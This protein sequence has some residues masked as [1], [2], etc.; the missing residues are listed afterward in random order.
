MTDA[1]SPAP[2]DPLQNGETMFD[3]LHGVTPQTLADLAP[4]HY[5]HLRTFFKSLEPSGLARIRNANP[6]AFAV[7]SGN[8][9]LPPRSSAVRPEDLRRMDAA[10]LAGFRQTNPLDFAR[11]TRP[12]LPR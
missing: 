1:P 3:Y 5:D 6:Q 4:E 11:L 7:L 10:Q 9:P 12:P 2:G 8:S